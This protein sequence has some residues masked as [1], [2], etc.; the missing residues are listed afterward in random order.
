M[1]SSSGRL[2]AE[3]DKSSNADASAEKHLHLVASIF[4]GSNRSREV[5]DYNTS[6]EWA[7]IDVLDLIEAVSDAFESWEMVR[8]DPRAQGYLVC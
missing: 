8:E 3:L 1:K 5:A 6:F 4:I 2:I 7:P